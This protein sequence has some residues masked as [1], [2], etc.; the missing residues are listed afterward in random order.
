M[1]GAFLVTDCQPLDNPRIPILSPS[2]DFTRLQI[3]EII[4]NLVHEWVGRK[5]TFTAVEIQARGSHVSVIMKIQESIALEATRE[6]ELK[7]RYPELLPKYSG[8]IHAI[9]GNYNNLTNAA[10]HQQ[11]I[12]AIMPITVE[13]VG[14]SVK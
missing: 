3:N 7:H 10:R 1:L 6:T 13:I 5:I 11:Q 4:A 9:L 12:H 14:V 8:D 2:K